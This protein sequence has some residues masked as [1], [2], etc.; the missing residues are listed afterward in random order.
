MGGDL[1]RAP[2]A[3]DALRRAAA[4]R[5]GG[6]HPQL[7]PASCRRRARRCSRRT[8]SLPST[9]RCTLPSTAR[10][11]PP[12]RTSRGRWIGSRSRS[13]RRQRS[14]RASSMRPARWRQGCGCSN[15]DARWR[16]RSGSAE[17]ASPLSRWS[18]CRGP[19]AD[20]PK[21]RLALGIAFPTPDHM[22]SFNKPLARF[23][24]PG[25]AA[26]YAWRPIE[27]SARIPTVLIARRRA[28][29][30]GADAG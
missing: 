11:R 10:C 26:A 18:A 17:R 3:A 5:V 7:G 9:P 21:A 27:L 25:L 12:S 8:P 20:A 14:S 4:K 29:E 6:V 1:G 2:L 19:R 16:R 15:R 28:R 30:R 13:G 24:A 22:R 23:G